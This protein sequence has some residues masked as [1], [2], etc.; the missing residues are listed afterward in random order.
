MFPIAVIKK[1]LPYD[2]VDYKFNN[3]I[4]DIHCACV[5][6]ALGNLHHCG[7]A[8]KRMLYGEEIKSSF[9]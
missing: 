1:L 5:T 3:F 6:P 9:R 7:R 2:R 4:S 8:P